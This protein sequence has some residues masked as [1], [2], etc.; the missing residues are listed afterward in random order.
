VVRPAPARPPKRRPRRRGRFLRFLQVLLSILML[1]AVPLVAM[2]L[3][4]GYGNGKSI[5]QDAVDVLRDIA[6]FLGLS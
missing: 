6:R 2:V 5:E 1:S 4:Y 3:A